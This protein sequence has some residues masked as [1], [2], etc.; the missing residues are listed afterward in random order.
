MQLTYWYIQ[1]SKFVIIF[2]TK[3][4]FDEGH[5]NNIYA[6]RVQYKITLKYRISKY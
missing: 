2:L 4:L 1:N 6:I 3:L 5:K